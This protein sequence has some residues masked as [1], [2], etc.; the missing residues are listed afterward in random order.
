M[1]PQIKDLNLS[2]FD[3]GDFVPILFD[4]LSN[5][6]IALWKFIEEDLKGYF[7]DIG[8]IEENGSFVGVVYKDYVVME[9]GYSDFL[10]HVRKGDYYHFSFFIKDYALFKKSKYKRNSL[11][12]LVK[13]C[14][15]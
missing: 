14:V 11:I 13:R 15:E 1:K 7:P 3:A 5:H 10:I 9:S 8:L 6:Y 2:Q 12:V 4:I